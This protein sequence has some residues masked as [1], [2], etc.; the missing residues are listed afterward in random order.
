MT[1]QERKTLQID[2]DLLYRYALRFQ[3][4]E[5]Q[6]DN[7][8]Q[9]ILEYDAEMSRIS[10]EIKDLERELQ[11]LQYRFGVCLAQFTFDYDNG[12]LINSN[13]LL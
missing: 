13:S 12:T 4:L 3:T 11:N 9:L 10:Q 8:R 6:L 2:R 1:K 7:R 5:R